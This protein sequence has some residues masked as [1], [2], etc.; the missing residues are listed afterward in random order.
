MGYE[1]SFRR[2]SEGI[3]PIKRGKSIDECTLLF[4]ADGL[5]N[6]NKASYY[7]YKAF[8][9]EFYL[10]IPEHL[11]QNVSY[12]KLV[13][14]ISFDRVTFEKTIS[15]A[16]KARFESKWDHVKL[17]SILDTLESGNRPKG[18]V[19]EYLD[20]VPSLW[21]N[22]SGLMARFMSPKKI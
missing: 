8:Q 1:F 16:A 11:R 21:V 12:Q 22:I 13:D 18:G 19:G 17:S 4:D 9:G 15:L 2:G 5:D 7:N 20:G 6:P 3:H 14:M 10:D